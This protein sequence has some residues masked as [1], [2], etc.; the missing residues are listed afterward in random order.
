MAIETQGY[1]N[2]AKTPTVQGYNAFNTATQQYME[3]GAR[4]RQEAQKL[5]GLLDLAQMTETDANVLA[6]FETIRQK[7]NAVIREGGEMTT[8][9]REMHQAL[10]EFRQ[11]DQALRTTITAINPP[12][13]TV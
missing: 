5:V 11:Y 6:H 4:M 8:A 7:L 1:L 13:Y 12:P 9:L 2:E 10:R 3:F